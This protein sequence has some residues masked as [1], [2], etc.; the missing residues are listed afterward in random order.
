MLIFEWR[1]S[2]VKNANR[3]S[4]GLDILAN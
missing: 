2:A 1:G 3:K 4:T